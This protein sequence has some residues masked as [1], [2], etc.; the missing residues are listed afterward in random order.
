[1]PKSKLIWAGTL[2]AAGAGLV[3]VAAGTF[4][5]ADFPKQRPHKQRSI[6]RMVRIPE[7]TFRMG[8]SLSAYADQHPAHDVFVGSFWM[9]EHEVTNRQFAQ[10]V[11]QTDYQT[12]AERRG[13]SLVFDRK[14]GEWAKTQGADWRH[15]G[16]PET[17]LV[18]RDELPV[19]HVS[20]YDARAYARWAGK[21]LPT[22]AQWEYA[23]RAGLRDADFPWGHR[24]LIDG[25]YQAN[26]SQGWFPEDLAADGFATLA[27]VKS[28]RP[29]R[30]G[31]YD[32]A[33][34]VWEWCEDWYAEDYYRSSPRE[35]PAGPARGRMRVRRGGSWVCAAGDGSGCKV[36]TRSKCDPDVCYQDV[37]FR[38]VR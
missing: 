11:A 18:G 34:N 4:R 31:L 26:C 36:S 15:P 1:M 24:E 9:D 2:L 27:P 25:R 14:T 10:F 20:W 13:W 23:S 38:C 28:Y 32:T 8:N 19:V 6:G 35:N 16:G 29:N 22:E 7:G 30:F 33:G 5:P 12:T 37:G 21:R 17:S 3:A